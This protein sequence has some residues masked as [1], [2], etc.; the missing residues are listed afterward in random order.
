MGTL[1]SGGERT[2]R[3]ARAK[4]G[5]TS[6]LG[7]RSGVQWVLSAGRRHGWTLGKPELLEWPIRCSLGNV[8]RC[9]L[10]PSV[11]WDPV[12]PPRAGSRGAY[13]LPFTV[14]RPPRVPSTLPAKTRGRAPMRA[15]AY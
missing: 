2:G 1:V 13:A 8:S 11:S 6:Q 14:P 9:V 5:I 4:D 10:C 12:F 3:E 7:G 15:E